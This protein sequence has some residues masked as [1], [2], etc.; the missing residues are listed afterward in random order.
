MAKEPVTNAYKLPDWTDQFDDCE[1]CESCEQLTKISLS[2]RLSSSITML[3]THGIITS[4]E[5]DK[6]RKRLNIIKVS[7][8]D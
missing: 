5:R 6:A 4:A 3:F 2:E 8:Y 7:D 1:V